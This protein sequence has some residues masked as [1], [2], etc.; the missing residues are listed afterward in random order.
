M[1]VSKL[2]SKSDLEFDWEPEG[3]PDLELD[4]L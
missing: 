2:T 3:D 4:P 1:D